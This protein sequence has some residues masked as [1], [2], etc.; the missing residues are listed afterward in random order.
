MRN[1]FLLSPLTIF[2]VFSFS[3]Q[4]QPGEGFV[5]VQGGRIWY[6]VVGKGKG[7]PLLLIHGG[8]GSNSCRTIPGYS[9]LS[10][11]RPVIFYDQLGS[12]RSDRPTDTIL[13]RTDRFAEEVVALRKAL[14]LKKI[15][16][17]GH[18]WGGTVLAEYMLTK[19]PKGVRSVIF[20]GPLLS[21]P[22]W[23][24]DANTLLL[25]LPQQLQ[26][27]I[28]TYERRRDYTAPSYI[29]ATDSFYARFL[30]VKN[31]YSFSPIECKG[32]P[33]FNEQVYNYMWAPTE[34]KATGTLINYD[35]SQD[36]WKITEPVIF[37]SGEFDEARPETMYHFQKLVPGSAVEIIKDAGHMTILDQP[38]TYTKAIRKFLNGVESR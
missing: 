3:Q 36:L 35:R 4:V 5:Q 20:A 14:G 29:S 11:E 1:I 6:Q 38:E 25:Q 18:S 33:D 37:I 2:Y 32:V 19:N 8:P 13:W 23:I 31:A 10:D 34:F 28:Q 24:E 27:T 16:I 17:L 9:M 30:S 22:K 7:T 21:T 12:G 15:H 26:D